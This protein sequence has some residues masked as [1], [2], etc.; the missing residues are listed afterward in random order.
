VHLVAIATGPGVSANYW[1]L[2]SPY[3]PTGRKRNPRVIGATN[4]VWVDAD[5]DGRFTA[6]RLQAE[7]LLKPVPA[8]AEPAALLAV[9][10]TA[11]EAV[12][13]QA[14]AILHKQ[15]ANLRDTAFTAALAKTPA[16][17][18]KGF[19]DYLATQK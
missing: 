14:A 4:P 9:L 13:A 19:R 17:V 3:Q 2:H 15:G 12:S 5:R 10:N 18:Q 6:P 1:R 16:P 11:D 7:S 8:G